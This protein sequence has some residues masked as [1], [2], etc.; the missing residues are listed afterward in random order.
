MQTISSFQL[1]DFLTKTYCTLKTDKILEGGVRV[2]L[3]Q[4]VCVQNS[5][6]YLHDDGSIIKITHKN[7]EVVTVSVRYDDNLSR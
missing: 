4:Y 2:T 3:G 5:A 1:S 7:E 6:H